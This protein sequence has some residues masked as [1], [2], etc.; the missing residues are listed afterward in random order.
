MEPSTLLPVAE[1]AELVGKSRPALMKAIQ[2]GRISA[3]RDA[4]GRWMVDPAEL[5]RVYAPVKPPTSNREAEVADGNRLVIEALQ[6]QIELLKTQ[7][8]DL[9]Q[10]R[11]LWQQQAHTLALAGPKKPLGF[12]DRLM[13]GSS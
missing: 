1:A 4:F 9:M 12:W 13:G 6:G 7:N 8:A 11:D 2:K 10:Q 5:T 3:T